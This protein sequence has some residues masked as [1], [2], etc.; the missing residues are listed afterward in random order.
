LG[1]CRVEDRECSLVAG[2]GFAS[3]SPVPLLGEPWELLAPCSK[4]LVPLLFKLAATSLHVHE[5]VH[6]VGH[7]E[8]GVGVEAHRFLRSPDLA[9]T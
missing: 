1:L 7:G 4:T 2:L 3:P 5:L 6:L 8:V 9:F